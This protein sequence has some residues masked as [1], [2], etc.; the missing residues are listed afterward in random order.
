MQHV[1]AFFCAAGIFRLRYRQR[2]FSESD[3]IVVVKK[4]C[5]KNKCSS[6]RV[7][8]KGCK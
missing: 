7:T 3:K 5:V 2:S 8:L 6:K 1:R 4:S